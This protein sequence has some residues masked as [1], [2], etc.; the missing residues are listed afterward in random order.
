MNLEELLAMRNGYRRLIAEEL[1]EFETEY[2]S[3][4]EY[5]RLF[6]LLTETTDE[7]KVI[8]EEIVYHDDVE[9]LATEIVESKTYSFAME[10]KLVRLEKQVKEQQITRTENE[11]RVM[12]KLSPEQQETT[13]D[14]M[15][16]PEATAF[17]GNVNRRTELHT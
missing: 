10:L 14:A 1:T 4:C 17:P 9:D 11:Q 16:S 8:N 13:T 5:E 12:S 15:L 6:C 2:I 7:I 3:Y